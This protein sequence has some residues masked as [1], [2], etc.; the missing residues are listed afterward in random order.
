MLNRDIIKRVAAKY[1]IKDKE[2]E[3]FSRDFGTPIRQRGYLQR[4]ELLDIVGW[5]SARQTPNAGEN[6]AKTVRCVTRFAFQIA[7]E[8]PAAAVHLLSYL[9]GVQVRMASA[10]LA[11]FDP[12]RYTVMDKRAWKT[13]QTLQRRDE[14]RVPLPTTEP[15]S[16]THLD[17]PDIFSQYLCCCRELAARHKVDLRTLDRCLWVSNGRHPAQVA[18]VDDC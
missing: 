3:L 16:E 18:G 9:K 4:G 17:N 1:E 13:L 5:K 8:T 7:K 11:V 12:R 14:T 6:E 15:F 2:V 10:I